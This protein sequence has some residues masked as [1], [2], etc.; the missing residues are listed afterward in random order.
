MKKIKYL[1]VIPALA[2][3]LSVFP[4]TKPA[5]AGSNFG[6]SFNYSVPVYDP[7]PTYYYPKTFVTSYG[8]WNDRPYWRGRYLERHDYRFKHRYPRNHYYSTRYERHYGRHYNY[9]HD[10]RRNRGYDRW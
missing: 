7:Y 6:I 5:Y 2:V 9:R 8:W 1:I 4:A 3:I 10:H